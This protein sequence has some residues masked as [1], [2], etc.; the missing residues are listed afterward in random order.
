MA[1]VCELVPTTEPELINGEVNLNKERALVS[2]REE[3]E[4]VDPDWILDMAASNHMTGLDTTMRGTVK[5]GDTSADRGTR[6]YAVRLQ[7]R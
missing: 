7:E 5:F 4:P 3:G 6:H 2:L 1:Q